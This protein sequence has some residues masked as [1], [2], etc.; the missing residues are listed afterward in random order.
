[1]SGA[2]SSMNACSSSGVGSNPQTSRYTRR[3][4]SASDTGAVRGALR[5]DEVGRDEPIERRGPAGH[6]APGDRRSGER[7]RRFPWLRRRR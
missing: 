2:G 3:A 5:A 4:N 7:E 1:M 6:I